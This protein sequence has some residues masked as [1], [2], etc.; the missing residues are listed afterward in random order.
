MQRGVL[1]KAVL[2]SQ[3]PSLIF[4]ATAGPA[5]MPHLATATKVEL[6]EGERVEITAWFCP[7]TL[8]NLAQAPHFSIVIWDPKEDRGYQILGENK[9]IE[10]PPMMNGYLEGKESSF[11]RVKRKL[12]MSVQRIL[13][14]KNAP[15]SDS[16]TR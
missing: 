12:F 6:G 7:Q 3:R 15:H 16:D 10:D 2:L 8:A 11:P 5:G 14:F 13:D 9:G 1:Q 4:V